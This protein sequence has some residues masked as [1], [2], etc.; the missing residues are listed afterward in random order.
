MPKASIVKDGVELKIG[1]QVLLR[2]GGAEELPYV[3]RIDKVGNK[4]RKSGYELNVTWYYRPEDVGRRQYHGE[5]ELFMSD[6]KDTVHSACILSKCTVWSID[7]YRELEIVTSTDFFWR[8]TYHTATR[9]FSP[10][11][12]PVYC[13]CELPENPDFF[14]A[15]CDMCLRW[16]HPHPCEGVDPA[17]VQATGKFS[18]RKCRQT[19]AAQAAAKNIGAGLEIPPPRAV[20]IQQGV[21][22]GTAGTGAGILKAAPTAQVNGNGQPPALTAAQLQ[23]WANGKSMVPGR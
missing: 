1:D 23:V 12:V 14:M 6:H 8:Y 13:S 11:Q 22:G 17:E 10:E 20:E 7:D 2:Q 21:G 5:R 18:C 9:R 15:E 4:D 16:F 19:H 3:A